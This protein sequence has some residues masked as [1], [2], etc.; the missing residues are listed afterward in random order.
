MNSG[1]RGWKLSTPFL[2]LS[3]VLQTTEKEQVCCQWQAPICEW[4]KL[5][6]SLGVN[7]G[8]TSQLG[9]LG[10]VGSCLAGQGTDHQGIQRCTAKGL[11][12]CCCSPSTSICCADLLITNW[13]H[14]HTQ[15]SCNIF[16]RNV[17]D[18]WHYQLQ[19]GGEGEKEFNPACVWGNVNSLQSRDWGLIDIIWPTNVLQSQPH[20]IAF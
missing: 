3:W 2:A 15:D 10:L 19:R 5:S 6:L 16:P 13:K 7:T 20:L 1:V 11:L 8:R 12:H 4:G 14:P 9:H 18:I 17:R